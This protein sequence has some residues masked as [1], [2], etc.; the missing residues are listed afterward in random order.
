MADDYLTKIIVNSNITSIPANTFRGIPN[1][2][3]AIIKSKS[4]DIFAFCK[5]K[6][7]K[8]LKHLNIYLYVWYNICWF[9]K[10]ER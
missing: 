3:C 6:T 7:K 5:K 9:M 8:S 10:K 1:L 2:E 4:I